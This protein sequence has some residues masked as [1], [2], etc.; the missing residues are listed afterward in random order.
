M[1]TL[2]KTDDSWA[3][4]RLRI[5]LGVVLLPHGTQKLLCWFGGYGFTGTLGFFTEQLRIPLVLAVLVILTESLG[6][7]SLIAGFLT[8]P[9]ALGMAIIM[10]VATWLVHWPYGFFINWSGQQAGEG[11]E[12]HLLVLGISLTLLVIGGGKWAVDGVIA[13]HLCSALRPH[14]ALA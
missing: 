1:A 10:A 3:G 6:A 2:F 9:A 5:T 12:Y 14:P 8:R 7:V 11:F 13:R 4:L